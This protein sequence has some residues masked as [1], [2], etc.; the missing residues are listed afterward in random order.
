MG[1]L[2]F[3]IYINDLPK[4]MPSDDELPVFF[5]DDTAISLKAS[6]EEEIGNNVVYL[7]CHEFEE[8]LL[9][10]VTMKNISPVLGD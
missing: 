3:F 1:P 2:L 10:V 8:A 9:V 6:N 7:F 5:A 4:C